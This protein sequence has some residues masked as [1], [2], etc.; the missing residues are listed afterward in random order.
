VGDDGAKVS[1]NGGTPGDDGGRLYDLRP[2]CVAV[3]KVMSGKWESKMG[4][5]SQCGRE[6]SCELS[7]ALALESASI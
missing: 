1:W 2:A 7:L 5:A 4:P 3:S 6:T